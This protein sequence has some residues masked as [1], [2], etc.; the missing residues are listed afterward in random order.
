MQTNAFCVWISER[1]NSEWFHLFPFP[2]LSAIWSLTTALCW[3]ADTSILPY[4]ERSADCSIRAIDS[5]LTTSTGVFSTAEQLLVDYAKAVQS[6]QKP[7]WS[8]VKRYIHLL[9]LI[10][11][12]EWFIQDWTTI[13]WQ[14]VGKWAMT[15][16]KEILTVLILCKNL[17][18]QA[19]VYIMRVSVSMTNEPLRACSW[20]RRCELLSLR[21]CV[22]D[23]TTCICRLNNA[24]ADFGRRCQ[25]A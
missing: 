18:M 14:A 16:D 15:T 2:G 5:L 1:E 19:S 21:R 6:K 17:L 25:F 20:A 4:K 12:F 22:A 13:L 11:C 8:P 3:Q 10:V 24:S 23:T 7:P 9:L